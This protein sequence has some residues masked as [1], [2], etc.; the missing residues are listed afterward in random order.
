MY[1]DLSYI[2]HDLI[3]TARDNAFSIVKTFG[4]LLLLL[5]FLTAAKL[6]RSELQRRERIGQLLPRPTMRVPGCDGHHGRLR[7]QCASSGSS[8]G[9]SSP[10]SWPI[11]PS[12]S[13]IPRGVFVVYR[14]LLRRR[15][16]RGGPV[17][18]VLLQHR[19]RAG[20]PRAGARRRLPQRSG[21]PHHHAGGHRWPAGG[22]V[23]CRH[24]VLGRL[25]GRPPRTTVQRQRP[26]HLR[27]T[28]RGWG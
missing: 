23:F 18:G 16:D 3:G 25:P 11:L 6:L 2:L 21:R 14:W 27:R 13:A 5:A 4:L 17:P 24:R 28:H 10:T 7:T 8:S 19:A 1:P 22:Q 12:F 15:T 20:S 26:G 9:T